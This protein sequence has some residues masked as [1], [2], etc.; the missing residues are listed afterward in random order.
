MAW[1][2]RAALGAVLENRCTPTLGAA[3]HF[4]LTFGHSALWIGHGV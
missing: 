3:T 1:N 4:L 2:W